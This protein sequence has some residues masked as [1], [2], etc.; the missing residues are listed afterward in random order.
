MSAVSPFQDAGGKLDAEAL[1]RD[2]PILQQP[3]NGKPLAFLDSAASAQT[4][5]RVIDAEA[6]VYREYYANIHRGVYKLSQQ[7]T[8]AYEGVRK[9]VRDLINAPDE[10]G[11]VYVSGTT[12]A[13]NL[14]AHSFVRPR[15]EPGDE[16]LLTEMEHHSNIVPWQVLAEETG[17]H[18]V[19]VPMDDNGEI[20]PADFASR[21][22]ERTKFA[23][24]VHVSN[25][26]G[27]INPVAELTSLA[28]E[29]DVPILVDGAQAVPHMPVDVQ[30]I[31]CDFYCF[32]AHKVYGPSGTGILWGRYELLAD[33]P[34]YQSGGDMI[35]YV[36]FAKT[37]YAKPPQRFEAGTPNIAGVIAMGE[38]I[39]YLREV[40]PARIAAHEQE[41][42][43]YA[44][45][46]LEAIDGLTIIGKASDKAGVISFV[47]D[48]AHPHDMGTIMDQEGVAIRAG[49]HCAQPVMEH[50]GLAAT[51]RASFGLYSTREDV[52]A[53]VRGIDKVKELF[54]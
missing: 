47:I 33:M 1:K 5:E 4:P 54:G 19:V 52:D 44:T 26:L 46:R 42:L 39:D 49:H 7:A 18:V 12:E 43:A 25:V 6:R 28:H 51:A 53:L 41:L 8:Q 36:T 20:D 30:A 15:L 29:R 22:S 16:I 23:S 11:V 45:E 40:G 50:F 9:K 14:V 17:A 27:T 38:A 35:R 32:S 21:I 34:P 10:R 31:G 48:G 2:F 24:V 3:M 37:E 13:I